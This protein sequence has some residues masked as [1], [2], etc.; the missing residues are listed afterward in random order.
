MAGAKVAPVTASLLGGPVSS[1][2]VH[3]PPS[4]GPLEGS[5]SLQREQSF[6]MAVILKARAA[7]G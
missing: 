4:A 7:I 5:A 1:P 3:W 2:G 6:R